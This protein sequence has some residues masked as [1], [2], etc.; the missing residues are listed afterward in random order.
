MWGQT[1]CFLLSSLALWRNRI[2][3]ISSKQIYQTLLC[4]IF[5]KINLYIF[6]TLVCLDQISYNNCGYL[7]RKALCLHLSYYFNA[8]P[9]YAGRHQKKLLWLIAASSVS[10]HIMNNGIYCDQPK[11]RI[12][13]IQVNY[14]MKYW[15][16]SII[17]GENMNIGPN[18]QLY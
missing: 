1:F 16:K 5:S 4:L 6:V 11:Q 2:L 3:Y 7:L 10:E 12:S 13:K 14:I 9:C 8:P 18:F 17:S 15:R